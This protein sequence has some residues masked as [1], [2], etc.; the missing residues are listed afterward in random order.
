MKYIIVVAIIMA[1][2]F[3]NEY[4]DVQENH[5]HSLSAMAEANRNFVFNYMSTSIGLGVSARDAVRLNNDAWGRFFNSVSS[6]YKEPLIDLFVVEKNKVIAGTNVEYRG[7]N[8]ADL[9]QKYKENLFFATA[10]INYQGQRFTVLSIVSERLYLNLK[11][12]SR[13]QSIILS[14]I[15]IVAAFLIFLWN[16]KIAISIRNKDADLL[17]KSSNLREALA[18]LLD[19]GLEQ[20]ATIQD[21]SQTIAVQQLALHNTTKRLRDINLDQQNLV[22]NLANETPIPLKNQNHLTPATDKIAD[23][24][25]FHSKDTRFQLNELETHTSRLTLASFD[26]LNHE[27]QF[28]FLKKQ[29]MEGPSKL[30]NLKSFKQKDFDI[31]RLRAPRLRF[32]RGKKIRTIIFDKNLRHLHEFK[33]RLETQDDYDIME[34]RSSVD[35]LN[36][37]NVQLVIFDLNVCETN[38]EALQAVQDL[39][40]MY[41]YLPIVVISGFVE[42]EVVFTSFLAGARSHL[43]KLEDLEDIVYQLDRVV[44][45]NEVIIGGIFA[46]AFLTLFMIREHLTH[47]PAQYLFRNL[48]GKT[49]TEIADEFHVTDENVSQSLKKALRNI[50]VESGKIEKLREIL[51][52]MT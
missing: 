46:T 41:P 14:L 40:I 35:D 45:K 24:A 25:D 19:K 15:T 31:N 7:L 8:E 10:F 38:L 43:S 22:F 21:Q 18:Q 17:P 12:E 30:L 42:P 32:E 5:N 33:R 4:F 29:A 23:L 9:T 20:D 44:F 6:R 1:A 27:Q 47:T 2:I 48:W 13:N 16:R 52:G 28:E 39:R 51:R 36:M 49:S 50:G 11:S 26:I 37:G 34:I 3:I